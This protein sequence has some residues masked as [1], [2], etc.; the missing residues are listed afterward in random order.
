MRRVAL[1]LAMSW[2]MAAQIP[3][4]LDL[5]GEW[6]IGP[7]DDPVYARAE[8]NDSDWQR[9]SLPRTRPFPMSETRWLRHRVEIPAV[10]DTSSL[11]LTMG[12]VSEVS[13]STSMECAWVLAADGSSPR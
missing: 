1:L 7:D 4:H 5:A 13:N 11:V 8:V 3:L 6:R 12:Q 2:P 10:A 9:Y